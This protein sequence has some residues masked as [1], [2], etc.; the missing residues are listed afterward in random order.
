MLILIDSIV[1]G[2]ATIW[3]GD[4]GDILGDKNVLLRL[5]RSHP[6]L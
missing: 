1:V 4:S 5:G 3:K 6:K 2:V